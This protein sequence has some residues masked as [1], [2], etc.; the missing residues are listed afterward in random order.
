MAPPRADASV[1]GCPEPSGEL[2]VGENEAIETA[3]SHELSV[4]RSSVR[5]EDGFDSTGSWFLENIDSFCSSMVRGGEA[6]G[7]EN[8]AVTS[9][10]AMNSEMTANEAHD[11]FE[12]T[13]SW[14]LDNVN[15]FCWLV[16]RILPSQMSVC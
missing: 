10:E 12:S 3:A 1:T 5:V 14:F 15:A 16:T 11:M 13:T 8:G 9:T 2:A 7:V 4:N 6:V